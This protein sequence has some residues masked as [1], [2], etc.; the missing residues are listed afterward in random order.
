[1][2]ERFAYE[3]LADDI[4]EQVRTGVLRPGDRIG[5]VR[6]MSRR[7]GVSISTV[8]QAYRLL[9]RRRVIRARPKSGFYVVA[10]ESARHDEPELTRPRPTPTPVTTGDLI[11]DVLAAAGDPELVPL[12]A[13][14][15]DP[16]LLPLGTLNRVMGAV[17]RRNPQRATS[18]MAPA[19][20]I[21][22]RREIARREWEAG[23]RV[24]GD[25]IWITCG[26]NEALALALRAVASPGDTVAVE[27]PAFFGVLQAIEAHGCQALE[28]PTDP[29]HGMRV[30]DL[31]R[32]LSEHRI[33]A[34]FVTPNFHNPLGALMPDDAKRALVRLAVERQFPVI[35]DD[36]FGELYFD[37]SRPRSLLA[38]E[39]DG[40]VI[41][42][43]SVSKV[44]APGYRIGWI[45]PGERFRRAV[46]RLKYSSSI[47][48]AAP[49]Q[50][51]V[52]EYL[53]GPGFDKHLKRLRE[54]FRGNVERLGFEVLE[55]FP[56]GTRIS[57]PRGGFV[58]WVQLPDGADA[59]ALHH[60]ARAEG[61][62]LS[63]GSI[64][65]AAGH[66]RDCI[67]LSA[68]HVWNERIEKG[69]DILAACL[70]SSLPRSREIIGQSP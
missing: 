8:L 37:G 29:R 53:A 65:S 11:T 34:C 15:P 39:T 58:L 60:A 50:L 5:S 51:A 30:D 56:P 16:D 1:M 31:G 13:A 45:V 70:N 43:S 68:G 12:G 21:E 63:P 18:F 23:C 62:S 19:G 40:W 2:A 38:E 64:Y 55:R 36:T 27:S 47:A 46:E 3:R 26:A 4:Q 17:L 7:R 24:T 22:L 67:R 28:I 52:A 49:T 35:E 25:D 6:W 61:V 69:L 32:A 57:R 59:V 66:Y 54:I 14:L 10:P 33:A 41:R 42:V 20:C 44:L 48:T 9:E